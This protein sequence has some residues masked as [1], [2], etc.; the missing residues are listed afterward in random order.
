M[1]LPR[2]DC[3]SVTTPFSLKKSFSSLSQVRLYKSNKNILNVLSLWLYQLD[4]SDKSKKYK[5]LPRSPGYFLLKDFTL[6]YSLTCSC[7][8]CHSP[9]SNGH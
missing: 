9:P 6:R 8:R 1:N 7:N 5:Q 4:A 2:S 3:V